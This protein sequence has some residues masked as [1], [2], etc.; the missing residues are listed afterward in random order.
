[1]P[2]TDYEVAELAYTLEREDL[3]IKGGMQDQYAAA[4]GGFNFIEFRCDRVVV[5]PLE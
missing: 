2:L 1:M 4:F 5:N 3:G